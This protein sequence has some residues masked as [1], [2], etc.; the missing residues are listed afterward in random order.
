M[1]I[2][3]DS[4]EPEHN[5]A[6][7]VRETGGGARAAVG[8]LLF[9]SCQYSILGCAPEGRLLCGCEWETLGVSLLPLIRTCGCFRSPPARSL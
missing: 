9:Y 1:Q 6:Q 2:G 4:V 3:P 5:E 8:G 7:G